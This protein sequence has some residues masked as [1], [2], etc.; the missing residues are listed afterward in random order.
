MM[1]ANQSKVYYDIW[2]LRNAECPEDCWDM[3]RK[4]GNRV[5]FIDQMQI[6]KP[7]THSPIECDSCFGGAAIYHTEYLDSC[8]YYSF[9][10]IGTQFPSQGCQTLTQQMH[11]GMVLTYFGGKEVCEHVPFHQQLRQR[12]LKLFINPRWIIAEG[13]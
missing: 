2:A 9:Y 3:V 6:P 1:G 12:K 7:K 5:K 4:T 10:P 11:D 8:R 13:K